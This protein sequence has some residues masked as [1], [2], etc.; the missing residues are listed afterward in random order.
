M[1]YIIYIRQLG[2]VRLCLDT[3]HIN[4]FILCVS[5]YDS[6][7]NQVDFVMDKFNFLEDATFDCDYCH[8]VS[9]T[10]CGTT[11]TCNMFAVIS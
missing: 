7:R 5:G 3:V 9:Y 10:V 4:G 2:E 11:T 1:Y 8:V 6:D